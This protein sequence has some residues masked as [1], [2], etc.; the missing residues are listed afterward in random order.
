MDRVINVRLKNVKVGSAMT[1][2]LTRYLCELRRS[3]TTCG[4]PLIRMA[5]FLIFW[6][7][8]VEIKWPPNDSFNEC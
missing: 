4:G 8:I 7:S 6:S 2:L 3:N 5:M 1:G